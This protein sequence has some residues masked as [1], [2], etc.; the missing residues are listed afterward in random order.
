[1][2]TLF[3]EIQQ[4]NLRI[5]TLDKYKKELNFKSIALRKKTLYEKSILNKVF[6]NRLN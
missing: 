1:M 5:L 3:L 6:T 4:T 2:I